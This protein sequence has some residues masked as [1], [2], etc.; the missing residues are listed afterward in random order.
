MAQAEVDGGIDVVQDVAGLDS[1]SADV[2]VDNSTLEGSD[3]QNPETQNCD[4]HQKVF[5]GRQ[6]SFQGLE[7]IPHSCKKNGKNE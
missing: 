5:D 3:D 1:G 2:L 7:L 6:S 4:D